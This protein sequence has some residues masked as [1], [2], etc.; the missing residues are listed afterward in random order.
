[1]NQFMLRA[2]ELAALGRGHVSPNPMVGCVI[3]HQLGDSEPRI[4]GEGWHQRYGEWHAEVN[5][6]RSVRPEDTHLLPEA[7]VYVTLEPCSHWGKT[8]P[9]ADLLIENRVR[10]VICCNDDPNPLVSGQ[11][12]DKLR[13]AGIEVETGVMAE[14]GRQLNARF[15]TFFEKKRPYII[16]K[17]A[18]TADGFIAG[19]Q[20]RQ[21]KISGDLAHRLVHRWR[22]EED[23]IM[24][25]TN[26]ARL[27][28]PRLNTRLW[29]GKNPTRIVVD[30]A[31]S[32]D[33][34]LHLFDGSQP[35]IVFHTCEDD[36]L[37]GRP[38][39]IHAF[40]HSLIHALT[41]LHERKIQS[42]LVE[43]GTSLINS[44][45]QAGLWDEMRVF[46][47]QAMLG[48]GI[49]APTVQGEMMSR[50]MVGLDELTVY[51]NSP[52]S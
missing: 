35:T 23:A 20:G 18:E 48:G 32:L 3:T 16:L 52:G 5:A 8:P 28:N 10:R 31:L 15:F 29:P 44:F 12:F 14:L 17:W 41:T 4:I 21:V 34:T 39:V 9:C 22:S 43:G 11:G 6:I 24:V 40:T 19:E 46:R 38:N 37:A 30:N 49:A 47:S 50:E 7:T 51:T 27:D 26:T 33:Q 36:T 25:G 2:L 45:L 1:M 13:A 42:I